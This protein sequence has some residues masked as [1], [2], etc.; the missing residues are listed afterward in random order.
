MLF[1]TEFEDDCVM[2]QSLH[3]LAILGKSIANP[4]GN[5]NN[6]VYNELTD[7][8]AG[9]YLNIFVCYSFNT[10][11]IYYLCYYECVNNFW[12]QG[13][14]PGPGAKDLCPTAS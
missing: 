2:P 4:Y 9:L 5:F 11:H 6:Y 8:I 3:I 1:Y 10:T 7:I 14:V 12:K 13:I